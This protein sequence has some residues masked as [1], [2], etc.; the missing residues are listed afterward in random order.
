M[1]NT[2]CILIQI[3][4]SCSNKG[5]NFRRISRRDLLLLTCRDLF[6]NL[7]ENEL[8]WQN[9][10]GEGNLPDQYKV[11]SEPTEDPGQAGTAALSSAFRLPRLGG[12]V[13]P[14]RSQGLSVT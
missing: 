1:A 3:R 7:F 11:T 10:M 6:A 5:Y 13:A 14:S 4:T 2:I 12:Q 8:M 9:I